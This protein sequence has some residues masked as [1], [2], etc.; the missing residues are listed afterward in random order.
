M[1]LDMWMQYNRDMDGSPS[2]SLKI[3]DFQDLEP[4]QS[5]YMKEIDRKVEEDFYTQMSYTKWIP[6]MTVVPDF[7]ESA[8]DKFERLNNNWDEDR[9]DIIGQNGNDGL[10]YV[11]RILHTVEEV[12]KMLEDG[13]DSLDPKHYNELPEALQHWNVVPVMGWDY[14]IGNATKYLWRAGKKESAHL[15]GIDKEIEDL[16]KAV[17]YINKRIEHLQK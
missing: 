7:P 12:E 14:Y 6:G 15:S 9:M 1:D 10:H 8:H 3:E 5:D 16:K 17:V 11:H 2:Q 4:D 13:H